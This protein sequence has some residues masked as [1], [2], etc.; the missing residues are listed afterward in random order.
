MER[1]L[2]R[3]VEAAETCGVSR[4]RM[5]ELIAE[6]VIPT[7]RIGNRICVPVEALREWINRQVAAQSH[8]APGAGTVQL[9]H[10]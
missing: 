5:Y 7:I 9:L 10:R 3:P 4:A 6:G 1:L 2:L 8:A